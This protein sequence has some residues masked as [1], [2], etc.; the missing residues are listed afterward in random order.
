MGALEA[1][2]AGVPVVVTHNCNMPEVTEFQ[3]GWEIDAKAGALTSALEAA[4]RNAPER[5]REL[6]HRGGDLIT[7]RYNSRHIAAA[8]A[9]VYRYVQNGI[10][11]R[12]VD[13]L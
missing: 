1:M 2:G 7:S 5:N 11:P 12:N 10:P 3:A 4:L 8:M 9:E 6:G 13:L